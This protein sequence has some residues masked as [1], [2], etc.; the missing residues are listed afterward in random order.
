VTAMMS[1]EAIC[2]VSAK[3]TGVGGDSM[4][5]ERPSKRIM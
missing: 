1:G 2:G 3:K 5:K 4:L